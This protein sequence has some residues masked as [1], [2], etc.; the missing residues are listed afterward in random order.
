MHNLIRSYCIIYIYCQFNIYIYICLFLVLNAISFGSSYPYLCYPCHGPPLAL[1]LE[2]LLAPPWAFD[3]ED[4]R[5]LPRSSKYLLLWNLFI[6]W[7]YMILYFYMMLLLLCF[8][9]H[10]L[11]HPTGPPSRFRIK[12]FQLTYFAM[13]RRIRHIC[14]ISVL[15]G[16]LGRCP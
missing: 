10:K 11:L 16:P 4:L 7:F 5:R 6:F 14:R 3:G 9:R 2:L 8:Q 15:S 12:S 1:D 13:A